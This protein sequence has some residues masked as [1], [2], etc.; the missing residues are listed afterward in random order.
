M[1]KLSNPKAVIRKGNYIKVSLEK[2]DPNLMNREL[3]RADLYFY[4]NIDCNVENIYAMFAIYNEEGEVTVT[5]LDGADLKNETI[6]KEKFLDIQVSAKFK[7]ALH[8]RRIDTCWF[9]GKDNIQ[10][11]VTILKSGEE[12]PCCD[13]C[14]EE[15]KANAEHV[16]PMDLQ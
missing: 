2:K 16:D 15:E 4:V 13:K 3:Y 5:I 6:T 10:C 1:I 7:N 14:Y 9:C 8:M 12:L 11:D